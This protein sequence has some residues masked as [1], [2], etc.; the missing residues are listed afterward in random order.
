MGIAIASGVRHQ[1]P[2]ALGGQQ[3]RYL[4]VAVNVVGPAMQQDHHR[5][6]GRADFG[7]GHIQQAGFHMLQRA[8]RA[9]GS[10]A[11]SR[12]CLRI[13]CT[14]DAEG[15]ELQQ[16]KGQQRRAHQA[17]GW[18]VQLCVHGE[19]PAAG[20]VP[21]SQLNVVVYPV[22]F[23][24]EVGLKVLYRS[25]VW[26]HCDTKVRGPAGPYTPGSAPDRVHRPAHRCTAC[27]F[28]PAP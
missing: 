7:V 22:C 20:G 2:V 15:T 24:K 1:H 5:A 11:G 8:E 18:G 17:A 23:E 4:G 28:S 13:L 10:C 26:T 12:R 25:G 3:R 19:S 14:G 21:G 6:I 27:R 9:V 16:R